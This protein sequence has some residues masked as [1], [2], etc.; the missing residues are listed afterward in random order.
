M[1]K[2]EEIVA[3]D[4]LGLRKSR[5]IEDLWIGMNPRQGEDWA[6]EGTWDEWVALARAILDRE[7]GR[8]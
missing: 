3:G 1:E 5:V 4:R 8:G 2:R 7:E 6:P